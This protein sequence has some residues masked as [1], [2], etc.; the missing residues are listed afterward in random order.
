MDMLA[1]LGGFKKV[2]ELMKAGRT[3]EARALQKGLQDEFLALL[4]ETE[5]L[6][7]QLSEVADVLDLSQCMSFDGQKYWIVE[8]DRKDGPYC[9]VCY[10]REGTLVRLTSHERHYQCKS[11]SNIYMKQAAP[12]AAKPVVRAAHGTQAKEP[13]PLFAK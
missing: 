1:Q 7:R 3:D 11:C 6:K 12:R 9:Q 13:I 2:L 10:D 4:Q 8:E 5:T